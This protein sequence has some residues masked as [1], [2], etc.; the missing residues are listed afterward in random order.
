MI[1]IQEKSPLEIPEE[2]CPAFP[3]PEFH[4]IQEEADV[5][6]ALRDQVERLGS[7][8]DR[9]A[10]KPFCRFVWLLNTNEYKSLQGYLAFRAGSERQHQFVP[11]VAT[12]RPASLRTAFAN[13]TLRRRFVVGRL[14]ERRSGYALGNLRG[15]LA[16]CADFHSQSRETLS[17][18]DLD[19]TSAS[20][21]LEKSAPLL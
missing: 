10:L 11:G 7:D 13:S 15:G 16:P 1:S 19:N 21:T 5:S 6:I 2:R 14:S 8:F 18:I 12:A 20:V 17:K 9:S 4:P 3:Y